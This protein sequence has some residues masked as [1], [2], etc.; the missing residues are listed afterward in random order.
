MLTKIEANQVSVEWIEHV[1]EQLRGTGAND[2]VHQRN[3]SSLHGAL[4]YLKVYGPAI[5]ET[6]K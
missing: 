6:Q 2:P 3:I 1:L 5:A 4:A